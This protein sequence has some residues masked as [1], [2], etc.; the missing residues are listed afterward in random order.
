M[1]QCRKC[2]EH[3]PSDKFGKDRSKPD[4]LS[5]RCKSCWQ[6]YW[7]SYYAKNGQTYRDRAS[8][9]RAENERQH[10]GMTLKR[11]YGITMDEYEQLLRAQG[12][13][14]AICGKPETRRNKQGVFRL[15]VDHD[16]S[17]GKIRSLLCS[18]CNS[19][20][21]Y[22]RDDPEIM[23]RALLYLMPDGAPIRWQGVV[24]HP[25]HTHEIMCALKGQR[26]SGEA[27]V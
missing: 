5:H 19:G 16:H 26:Q 20:L 27:F 18:M 24:P 17:T 21:G 15:H 25:F 12:G 23:K 7:D 11:K 3:L 1:K 4:G 9:W 2:K 8:K 14:C 6:A 22:F 10:S 13:V